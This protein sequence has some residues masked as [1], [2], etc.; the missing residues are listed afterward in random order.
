[1]ED[2]PLASPRS[3]TVTV[4]G[5]RVHL[6]GTIKGLLSEQDLVTEHLSKHSPSAVGL[7]IGPQELKGL[8]SV[9]DGKVRS[10][11]LSSYEKVYALKL[12]RFGEVQVPPPSLVGALRWSMENDARVIALDYSDDEYDRVYTETIGGMTLIRQSLRLKSLNRRKVRSTTPEAFCLEWDSWVNRPSGFRRLERKRELHF[13]ERVRAVAA[14][15]TPLVVV[16]ELER[17]DGIISSLR[18]DRI[19]EGK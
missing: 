18:E 7:H 6:L 17:L 8:R 14:K 16:L 3:R 13:A 12:S 9:I 2:S 1:M 4:G 19:P 5:R 11:Y 15:H 10:T